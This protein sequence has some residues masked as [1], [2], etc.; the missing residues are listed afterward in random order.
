MKFII[1]ANGVTDQQAFTYVHSVVID[2]LVSKDN[3]C[4]CYI[5]TFTNGVVVQAELTKTGTH[6]FRVFREVK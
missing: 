2:G 1:Y 5:T 3:T 4:Y 6:T